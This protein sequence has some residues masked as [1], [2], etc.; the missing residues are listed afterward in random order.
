MCAYLGGTSRHKAAAC[1]QWRFHKWILF[2]GILNG[3]AQLQPMHAVSL[4]DHR[5]GL[6]VIIVSPYLELF[7]HDLGLGISGSGIVISD[8]SH[9]QG[10]SNL[11]P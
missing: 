10:A 4:H 1:K 9:L 5:A 3:H 2:N 8:I 11:G 6:R 7:H